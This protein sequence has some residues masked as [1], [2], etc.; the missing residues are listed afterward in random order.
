MFSSS[1][2]YGS[3]EILPSISTHI[4]KG[5]CIMCQS[6][7][8]SSKVYLITCPYNLGM[9]VIYK[10]IKLLS[11][12]KRVLVFLHA[13]LLNGCSGENKKWRISIRW[14][15]NGGKKNRDRES[16]VFLELIGGNY[17][18]R[19]LYLLFLKHF[20]SWILLIKKK[21][22]SVEKMGSYSTLLKEKTF[23]PNSYFS[24]YK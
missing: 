19:I 22:V 15:K 23:S 7:K 18:K 6:T 24:P 9:C 10:G 20:K 11:W 13:L 14:K 3:V 5:P 16:L 4:V 17:F 12:N 21:S 1:S 8:T 2:V